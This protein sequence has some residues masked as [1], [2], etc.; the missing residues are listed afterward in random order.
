[1]G[2]AEARHKRFLLNGDLLWIRVSDSKALPFP[3]LG[4]ISAD[5]RFGQFVWTSKLGYRLIDSKKVKADASVGARFWHVGQKLSFTPSR[6][7]LNFSSS[8]NWADILVGG[9]VQFP[10]GEKAAI[11]TLGDVGGWGATSKLDYQFAAVLRYKIHPKWTLG[12][13]YRYFFV[14]YRGANSS[15][16]NL[17]TAG[18][19]VGV[20]YTLK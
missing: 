8:Q 19:V 7:G 9:R 11:D 14:D 15:I 10:L 1:M 18:P 2:A 4:E 3:R 12:A 5:A 16:Y 6:F 13:G 20:T 17:V